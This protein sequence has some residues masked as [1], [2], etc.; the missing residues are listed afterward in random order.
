MGAGPAGSTCAVALAEAG[1]RVLLAEGSRLTRARPADTLAPA[2]LRRLS[3]F[4]G[5]QALSPAVAVPCRGV[6]AQWGAG[7]PQ[8]ADYE[9]DPNGLGG[10]VMR[11][12]LDRLL[13]ERAKAAGVDA[14]LGW[15]ELRRGEEKARGLTRVD[16]VTDD[17]AVTESARMIVNATGRNSTLP[18]GER[19]YGDSRLAYWTIL[20][21]ARTDQMLWVEKTADDWWYLV[22]LPDGSAQLVMVTSCRATKGGAIDRKGF[23]EERFECCRFLREALPD[24]LPDEFR[25][26]G[27]DARVSRLIPPV[28]GN[29]LSI[30]DAS[31][32]CD[33]LSG[34]GWLRAFESASAATQAIT[35]V[36]ASGHRTA[37]DDFARTLERAGHDH[38]L[39]SSRYHAVAASS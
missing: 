7:E 30:G 13:F 19:I 12:A 39:E 25:V 5:S 22:Q 34:Q 17:G 26:S 37:L 38:L 1:W 21:A 4:L 3:S 9:F 6:V 15:F 33:P 29:C 27:G 20:P 2:A 14:R 35:G 36:L 8:I 18:G 16:F 23:F 32:A 31:C 24:K 10:T 11:P 28:A